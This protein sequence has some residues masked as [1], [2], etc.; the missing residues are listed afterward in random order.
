[1]RRR[2]GWS[3]VGLLAT[4]FV[5]AGVLKWLDPATFTE[6]IHA[7]RLTPYALSYFAALYLPPFEILSALGLLW[8]K[9]RGPALLL[10]GALL[11]VFTLAIALAWW[12]GLDIDCGCFGGSVETGQY[13]TAILRDLALIALV[14]MAWWGFRTEPAP[15]P[16]L[17]AEAQPL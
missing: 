14:G 11:V 13:L 4:T 5:Y 1:M 15:S 7:Y 6:Q 10:L 16:R 9:S 17:T 3:S 8:R 12:R 2:I